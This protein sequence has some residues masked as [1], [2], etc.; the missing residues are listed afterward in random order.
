MLSSELIDD[1]GYGSP[2]INIQDKGSKEKTPPIQAAGRT[3]ATLDDL[4]ITFETVLDVN[5]HLNHQIE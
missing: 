3:F 2:P 1:Y 5:D 4:I